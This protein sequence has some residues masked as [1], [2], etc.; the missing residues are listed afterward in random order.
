M[1]TKYSWVQTHKQ[2]NSQKRISLKTVNHQ[3]ENTTSCFKASVLERQ[4][5]QGYR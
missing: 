4:N 3:S 1:E 5:L 2:T